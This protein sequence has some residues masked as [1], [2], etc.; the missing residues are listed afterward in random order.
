MTSG[1]KK[2]TSVAEIL[3]VMHGNS[4]REK[5]ASP[6]FSVRVVFL[7]ENEKHCLSGFNKIGKGRFP[8][9]GICKS[10]LLHSEKTQDKLHKINYMV[11]RSSFELAG[12]VV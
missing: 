2:H 4:K 1:W 9:E 6:N 8:G 11:I 12:V 10:T 5:D 7:S 3:V